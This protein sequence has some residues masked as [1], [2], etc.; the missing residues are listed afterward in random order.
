MP[1]TYILKLFE[2]LS[3]SLAPEVAF[4]ISGGKAK[5]TGGTAKSGQVFTCLY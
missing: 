2:L 3:S 1:Q 4:K 5:S